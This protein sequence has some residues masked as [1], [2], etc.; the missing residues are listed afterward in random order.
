MVSPITRRPIR[1]AKTDPLHVD[2]DLAR[3]RH[4]DRHLL[5][6][7]LSLGAVR[8]YA[9][10]VRVFIAVIISLLPEPVEGPR[11]DSPSPLS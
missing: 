8:T 2:D 9:R 10:M 7:A 4:R 6:L 3:G 1:A 11:L 5:Y